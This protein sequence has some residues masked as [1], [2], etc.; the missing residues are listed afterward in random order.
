M[1]DEEGDRARL[2]A[3]LF[4]FV[5][6]VQLL[7]MLVGPTDWIAEFWRFVF[8]VPAGLFARSWWR[9]R[10][11]RI[12]SVAYASLW[13]ALNL[14]AGVEVVRTAP[15]MAAQINLPPPAIPGWFIPLSAASSISFV[16]VTILIVT[17][18]PSR[19]RR[20]AGQALF[21]IFAVLFLAVHLAQVYGL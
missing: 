21:A 11:P 19:G 7:I 12:A 9:G 4:G 14:Y 15:L 13:S 17:G 18:R 10:R 6:A 8:L 3:V 1:D 2:A 20:I 16:A 5:A